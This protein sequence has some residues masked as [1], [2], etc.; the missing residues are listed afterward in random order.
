MANFKLFLQNVNH[1]KDAQSLL[2]ATY[3]KN[4]NFLTVV[5]DPYLYNNVNC[6]H[7]LLYTK[8]VAIHNNIK[9]VNCTIVSSDYIIKVKTNDTILFGLYFPPSIDLESQF[10]ILLKNVKELFQQNLIILGDFNARLK[11]MENKTFIRNL[12]KYAI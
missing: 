4:C 2:F 12:R 10:I 6:K 9:D 1:F 8:F 5:C 7:F 11:I 3:P